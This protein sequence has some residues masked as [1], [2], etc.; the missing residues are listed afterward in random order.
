MVWTADVLG[1]ARFLGHFYLLTDAA[2]LLY[3]AHASSNGGTTVV[4]RGPPAFVTAHL[5]SAAPAVGNSDHKSAIVPV[6]K[7][8]AALVPP[9][10]TEPDSGP[11]LVMPTPGA[12]RPR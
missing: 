8:A 5:T 9:A 7:G 3:A 12:L 2:S 10:V 4:R 11:R 1:L 6:T